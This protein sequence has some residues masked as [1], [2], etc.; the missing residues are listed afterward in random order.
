MFES[1]FIALAFIDKALVEWLSAVLF[2][3]KVTLL[4]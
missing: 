1:F 2:E 4:F 3:I